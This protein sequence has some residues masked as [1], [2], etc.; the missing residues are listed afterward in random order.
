MS[1]INNKFHKTLKIMDTYT[2]REKH[3]SSPRKFPNITYALTTVIHNLLP[4]PK[5]GITYSETVNTTTV[6]N[7]PQAKY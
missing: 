3:V 4:K 5:N 7:K 6:D 1:T 2:L